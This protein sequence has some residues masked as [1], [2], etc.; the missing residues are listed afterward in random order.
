MTRLYGSDD[1][2]P[3]RPGDVY[4]P[5]QSVNFLTAHDGFC[6]YDMVSYNQK[7]N[8]ANGDHNRDGCYHNLSWNCGA[9]G[10]ESICPS[11]LLA[12]APGEELFRP[13]DACQ[14]DADVLRRR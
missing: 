7:H 6:L 12:K 5:Y 8:E 10:D 2:F 11:A 1:L 13:A 9:E 3:D 4:H 14:R